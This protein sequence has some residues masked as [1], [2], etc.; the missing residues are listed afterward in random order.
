MHW[1]VKDRWGNEI[2][3]TEERW[4]HICERHWELEGMLDKVLETVQYG[5][6]RQDPLDPTKYKY[7]WEFDDLPFHYTRIIAVVR[8][9]VKKFIIT[10]YPK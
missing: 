9:G 2:T 4:L 3:L 1:K 10:A 5:R 7:W 6:R 8:L